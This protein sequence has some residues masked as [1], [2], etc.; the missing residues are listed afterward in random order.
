MPDDLIKRPRLLWQS[1]ASKHNAE[2]ARVQVWDVFSELFLDTSRN[3]EEKDWMAELLADSPF[4]LEELEHILSHEVSPVCSPNLFEWPG[5]EWLMFEPDWLIE[6]CLARQKKKPF[7]QPAH[8]RQK[9]MIDRFVD[10]LANLNSETLLSRVERFRNR[11]SPDESVSELKL[12]ARV[13]HYSTA[14]C[15]RTHAMRTGFGCPM[16]ARGHFH[17]CRLY[18]DENESIEPGETKEVEIRFLCPSLVYPKISQEIPY[19]LW[20][21]KVIAHVEILAIDVTRKEP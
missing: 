20:E 3:E 12:N 11:F 17:D 14:C 7:K 8:P 18:F 16:A 19:Y 10:T 13:E 5:G 9:S 6:R 1:Q 2:L 21:G 15:G 4:T